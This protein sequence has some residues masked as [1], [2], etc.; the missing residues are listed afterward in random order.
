MTK[1]YILFLNVKGY[2]ANN[3]S[4]RTQVTKGHNNQ[5]TTNTLIK[6][7]DTKKTTTS[8]INRKTEIKKDIICNKSANDGGALVMMCERDKK[9]CFPKHTSK[10]FA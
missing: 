6:I 7:K 5:D 8:L 4:R 10:V 3:K 2:K 1:G 9:K